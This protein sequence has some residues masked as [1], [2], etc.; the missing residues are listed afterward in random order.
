MPADAHPF[1]VVQAFLDRQGELWGARRDVITAAARTTALAAEAI[2]ES[3]LARDGVRLDAQF[4][5]TH[6]DIA[7]IYEGTAIERPTAQPSPEALLGD[8]REVG[9][10]VGWTLGQLSDALELRSDGDRRTVFI[11]FEH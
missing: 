6:L 1:L 10:Y 8:E 9:R 3:G 7:V 4:D 5:E 11:R 2:L